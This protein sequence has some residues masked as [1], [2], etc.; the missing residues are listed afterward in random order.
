MKA[1]LE[2]S[3]YSEQNSLW[4]LV[5]FEPVHHRY[6][7][8][9]LFNM[10]FSTKWIK[11]GGSPVLPEKQSCGYPQR[12]WKPVYL[13]S[14][15]LLGTWN[16]QGTTSQQKWA[17]HRVKRLRKEEGTIQNLW[18]LWTLNVPSLFLLNRILCILRKMM[19]TSLLKA[20]S[21]L[22]TFLLSAHPRP[23]KLTPSSS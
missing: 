21:L 6:A 15:S 11:K 3:W 4:S 17:L 1:S 7:Q 9:H 19:S 16:S 14:R 23:Q 22:Q 5:H 8:A 20:A 12:W 10:W 2:H 18:Q 13:Q